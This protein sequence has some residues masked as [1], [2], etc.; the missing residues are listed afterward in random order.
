V[1]NYT[2]SGIDRRIKVAS[3]LYSLSTSYFLPEDRFEYIGSYGSGQMISYGAQ[4]DLFLATT[5]WNCHK[6]HSGRVLHTIVRK[7]VPLLYIIE[8]YHDSVSLGESS[9]GADSLRR[10]FVGANLDMNVNRK[11][12]RMNW[13]Q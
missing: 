1:K 7:G 4:P 10:G 13:N 9:S 5:R 11:V 3:C 2:G 12:E 6:I 8:V